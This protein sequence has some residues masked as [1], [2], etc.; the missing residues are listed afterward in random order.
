MLL[1]ERTARRK[2]RR[3]KR[4]DKA[5]LV[6]ESE[7]KTREVALASTAA[8]ASNIVIP[9]FPLKADAAVIDAKTA[10]P[11]REVATIQCGHLLSI[12][13]QRHVHA[14]ITMPTMTSEADAKTAA[15]AREVATIQ[16]GHLL[17]ITRQHHVHAQITIPTMTSETESAGSLFTPSVTRELPPL[18]SSTDVFGPLPGNRTEVL[19]EMSACYFDDIK[20]NVAKLT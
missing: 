6:D 20:I 19:D 9:M 1:R 3:R 12:T 14:Q 13:Q 16:Y 2:P 15:P 18:C 5:K 7:N 17:S 11:A 8:R 4:G 10:A